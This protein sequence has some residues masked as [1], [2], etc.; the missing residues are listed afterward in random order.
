M[1][2][3]ALGIAALVVVGPAAA[4][5]H[6]KHHAHG[7]KPVYVSPKGAAKKSNTS[8][9]SAKYDSIQTAIEAA[10]LKGTS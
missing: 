7:P 9:K 5:S 10:K 1:L 3:A 4:K 6:K 8:C 2:A